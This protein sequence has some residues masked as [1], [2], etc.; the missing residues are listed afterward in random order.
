MGIICWAAMARGGSKVKSSNSGSSSSSPLNFLGN[1][2]ARKFLHQSLSFGLIVASALFI[3]KILSIITFTESPIVVVLTGSME[4]SFYKGDL[5]FLW[6]NEVRPVQSGDI[7][8]YNI[9]GRQPAI[10]IVHR[11]MNAHTDRQTGE[12]VILTKGD[13]NSVDDRGLYNRGQLWIVPDDILGRVVG[14]LPYIGYVTILMNEYEWA[15][16]A[17]IGGLFIFVLIS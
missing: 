17:L 1:M 5:L 16:Y 3:W 4:P 7:V 9:H 14:F 12:Q 6:K 10:P 11:V 2:G 15:K 8:V 13:N